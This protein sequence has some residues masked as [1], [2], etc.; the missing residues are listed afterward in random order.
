[1]NARSIVAGLRALRELRDHVGDTYLLAMVRVGFGLLLGNEAWL[2]T[3]DFLHAGYFGN[4]FHEP[5]LPEWLVPSEG[6][7][8]GVLAAQWVAAALVVLGRG[9]RPALLVAASL[10]IYVVLCDRLWYHHY[11]HTMAAFCTLLAFAPC[12]RHLVPGR[13]PVEGPAPIWAQV[14]M[15]AQVSVMYLTSAGTKLLD[16]DWRGGLMMRGMVANFARLMHGRGVPVEVLDLMRTPIGASLLAKGAITTELSLA[17]LLWWPRTRRLAL[18]VGLL[19]HLSIT[20]MT[21][22][23]LFTA[24]MLLVYLLFCTP[25]SRARVVR[26]DPDKHAA[27]NVVDALDWLQR[28]RLD[29]QKGAS[30][31]IVARDGT[32]LHGPQALA[33][34]AGALPAVFVLWPLLAIVAAADSARARFRRTTGQ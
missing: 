5:Y 20:L 10:L 31:A 23:R 27:Q 21:P 25:D 24:E 18:W 6:L 11:R 28:F 32:E 22:V 30:F 16:P 14:A 4:H 26:F 12:D 29:P 3:Q 17:V 33:E 13:A 9:A 7:Y 15:K 2:A 1:V 34:A 19:F 8:Q